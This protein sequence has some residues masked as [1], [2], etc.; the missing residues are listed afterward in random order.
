M[1]MARKAGSEPA[2]THGFNDI[3]G[4]IFLALAFLMLVALFSYDR[5]DLAI[6]SIPPNRQ[7]HNWI[8]I[9]GARSGYGLF[10]VFGAAAYM[11]PVI[12]LFA[13]LQKE[14]VAGLTAGAVKG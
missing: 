12:L 7:I 1:S 4:I 3:V 6:N 11:L 9:F 14:F 8:G 10:F 13:L 5:N 2:D